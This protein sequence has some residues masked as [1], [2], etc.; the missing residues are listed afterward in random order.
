MTHFTSQ[1]N[2]HAIMYSMATFVLFC[3]H[4]AS[5]TLTTPSSTTCSPLTKSTTLLPHP[6][7]PRPPSGSGSPLLEWTFVAQRLPPTTVSGRP[8]LLRTTNKPLSLSLTHRIPL[9]PDFFSFTVT[10][11][12]AASLVGSQYYFYNHVSGQ[13]VARLAE[14]SRVPAFVHAHIDFVAPSV[15]FPVVQRCGIPH[16]LP[17]LHITNV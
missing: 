15:R 16:T 7:P 1:H 14:P 6:T 9:R 4:T 2:T 8:R 17:Q 5:L 13:T 11:S 3:F 10:A 12:Q